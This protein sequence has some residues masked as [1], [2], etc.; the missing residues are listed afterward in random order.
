MGHHRHTLSSLP[1][2]PAAP[3]RKALDIGYR[4]IDCAAV[5]GNEVLVGEGIKDFVSAGNREQL[6]IT[7]KVG[8]GRRMAWPLL[9]V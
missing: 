4:H 8:Q 9:T 6:F 7:S 5:Y 3:C 2:A 1:P